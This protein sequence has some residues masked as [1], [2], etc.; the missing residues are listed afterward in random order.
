MD[1]RSFLSSSKE[2]LL[3]CLPELAEEKISDSNSCIEL[4]SIYY[5]QVRELPLTSTKLGNENKLG[6]KY[7]S[8]G[9][10]KRK[11]KISR[12]IFLT[13][14]PAY[15]SS[16]PILPSR[17]STSS[18]QYSM[19]HDDLLKSIDNSVKNVTPNLHYLSHTPIQT[20]PRSFGRQAGTNRSK[21]SFQSD[22][23]ND[24][25]VP[26]IPPK[27][28]TLRSYSSLPYKYR[29]F[30]C[31]VNEDSTNSLDFDQSNSNLAIISLSQLLL[32]V[33]LPVVVKIVR[34]YCVDEEY[35]D[36][37]T[38][39]ALTEGDQLL[40]SN[41]CFKDCAKIY[42]SEDAKTISIPDDSECQYELMS[43]IPNFDNVSSISVDDLI[44]IKC[45]SGRLRVLN[46]FY[47]HKIGEIPSNSIVSIVGYDN[48]LKSIV[49]QNQQ[50]IKFL[51]SNQCIGKFTTHLSRIPSKF[52]NHLDMCKL[53]QRVIIR[54]DYYTG[55]MKQY[56]NGKV[57]Y[58]EHYGK[59]DFLFCKEIVNIE[60][61]LTPGKSWILPID[62]EIWVEK[63]QEM[64]VI[65]HGYDVLIPD[66]D[67]DK[68]DHG[69]IS[70]DPKQRFYDK[71]ISDLKILKKR[72]EFKVSQIQKELRDTKEK[73]ENTISMLAE[74]NN[75]LKEKIQGLKQN[76]CQGD[77]IFNST[78]NSI[79]RYPS[80]P[81]LLEEHKQGITL[82]DVVKMNTTETIN[83]LHQLNLSPYT[84][85]FEKERI[86]GDFFLLL[87]E[88]DLIDLNVSKRLDRKKILRVKELLTTGENISNYLNS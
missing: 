81:Q 36:I 79:E 39:K 20:L 26:P 76:Y 7:G 28:P 41:L 55:F 85:T 18:L 73:A 34:G 68:V 46:D 21:N 15:E 52:Q 64:R 6:L 50:N 87:E 30:S 45:T 57:G 78:G 27:A 2:N 86:N 24:D 75:H 62:D 67:Y 80:M 4:E 33:T 44:K 88:S 48:N 74:Q 49:I 29:R 58:V 13:D 10:N 71:E 1:K 53:P 63:M 51:I 59:E 16:S 35:Y 9:D 42:L 32:E 65:E 72:L 54:G 47:H 60:S 69:I 38:K 56:V 61:T 43:T 3:E 17:L 5:S 11:K 70:K 14:S 66:G 31:I 82:E 37:E 8:S 25:Q 19:S 40:V 77:Q 22:T 84:E 12:K 23:S 83:L